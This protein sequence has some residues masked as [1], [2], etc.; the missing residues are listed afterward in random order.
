VR[1]TEREGDARLVWLELTPEGS[2]AAGEL[3]AARAARFAELL[4]NIPAEQRPAVIDA[5]TTLVE[6]AT[7]Q[8]KPVGAGGM[9]RG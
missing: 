1:R 9:T 3:A 7:G 5:L 8:P 4:R 6:A 2:R